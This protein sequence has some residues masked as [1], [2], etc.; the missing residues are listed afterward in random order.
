MIRN[1]TAIAGFAALVAFPAAAETIEVKMLNK[2]ADGSAMVFEPDYVKL[3]PGDTLKFIAT[4][5]SHNAESIKGRAP[6]G[7]ANF[8]GKINEEIEVTFDVE[9]WYAIQCRPHY[10]MGMAMAV[11]VGDADVPADFLEGRMPR[12]AKER[13]EA[14]IAN[15]S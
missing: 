2:G 6:E 9:G 10:A 5:R 13:L 14:A 8:K 15:G 4:D 7:S 11:E 3:A 1:I 12:R